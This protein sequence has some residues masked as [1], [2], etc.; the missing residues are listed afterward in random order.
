MVA[1]VQLASQR[2]AD[3]QLER[4]LDHQLVSALVVFVAGRLAKVVRVALKSAA[5]ARKPREILVA[6]WLGWLDVEPTLRT[7]LMEVTEVRCG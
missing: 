3:R 4:R 5:L 7:A 2:A 1:V 6:V